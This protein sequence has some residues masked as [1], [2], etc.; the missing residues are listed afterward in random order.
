VSEERRRT[1][2]TTIYLRENNLT[3]KLLVR[4]GDPT[5]T[6]PCA[7]TVHD[8]GHATAHYV[9][10]ADVEYASLGELEEAHLVDLSHLPRVEA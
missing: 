7:V 10:E 9:D 1:M 2:T 4:G 6:L 8:N 5:L 3:G